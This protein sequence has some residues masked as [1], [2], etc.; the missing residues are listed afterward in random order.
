TL[1]ALA[2]AYVHTVSLSQLILAA[3]MGLLRSRRFRDLSIIIFALFGTICSF[4]N[5]LVARLF[6][7]RGSNGEP[8]DLAAT[9]AAAHLDQYLRWTPPGMAA[10]SIVLADRGDY[11]AAF[12]WL[13]GAALLVPVAL[14]LWAVILDRGITSAESAGAGGGR[15]RRAR[16]VVLAGNGAA[17]AHP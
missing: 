14:F 10:Q 7:P 3:L 12:P 16:A 11:L 15:R 9:L 13:L 6:I 17:I 2:L 5:Q 1:V 8:P 4:S